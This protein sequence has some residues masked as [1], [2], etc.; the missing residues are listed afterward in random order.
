[1][2]ERKPQSDSER[3]DAIDKLIELN[4]QLLSGEG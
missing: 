2:V 1:M 3:R 4:I